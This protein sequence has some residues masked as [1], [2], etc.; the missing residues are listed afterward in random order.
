MTLSLH[1]DLVL[2]DVAATV[3]HYLFNQCSVI[4]RTVSQQCAQNA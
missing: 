3:S 4:L 2:T 1:V